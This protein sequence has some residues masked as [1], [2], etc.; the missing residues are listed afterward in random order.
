MHVD[1]LY[2]MHSENSLIRKKTRFFDLTNIYKYDNWI[3]YLV[4]NK[5]RLE[6]LRIIENLIFE[7]INF[8]L[9]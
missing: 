4:D 5:T 2:I 8:K 7:R 9:Y 6:F 1:R 3:T